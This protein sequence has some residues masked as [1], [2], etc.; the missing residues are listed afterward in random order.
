MDLITGLPYWLLKNGLVAGYPKLEKSIKT[1]IVIIGGGIS[2]SLS[3]YILTKAGFECVVVDA[4]N[5]G[6]GSTCASTSLLQY[7]LDMPLSQLSALIGFQKAARAYQCCSEAIDAL[8]G[9]FSR[10]RF[11]VF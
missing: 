8:Q 6:M 9:N 1:G 5:I 2:G 7:E 10:N 11:S 3:A 4:R